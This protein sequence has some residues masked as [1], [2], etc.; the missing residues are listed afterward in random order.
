MFT[1]FKFFFCL[2]FVVC[3]HLPSFCTLGYINSP[4]MKM[5]S[6]YRKNLS[7]AQIQENPTPRRS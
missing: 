1:F 4:V 3:G 5:F 6:I 7:C 2:Y